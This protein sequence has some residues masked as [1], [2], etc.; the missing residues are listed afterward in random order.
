[1]DLLEKYII[2]VDE[3]KTLTERNVIP[4]RKN[5]LK[6]FS[7]QELVLKIVLLRK[8]MMEGEEIYIKNVLND[9]K[10]VC[11]KED[12]EDIHKL[13]TKINQLFN[14]E[15][16]YSLPNS[17]IQH[18]YHSVTDLLYGL[19]LHSD[20]EKIEN[21]ILSDKELKKHL[22]FRFIKEFDPIIYK[23]YDMIKKSIKLDFSEPIEQKS[24]ILHFI[25]KTKVNRKVKR[26]PYW[27][28]IDGYDAFP[29]DVKK[30]LSELS[31]K[32]KQVLNITQ[33]FISLLCEEKINTQKILKLL[34]FSSPISQHLDENSKQLKSFNNIVLSTKIRYSLDLKYAY[35]LLF[36]NGEY[37]F[38]VEK[39]Q[40]IPEAYCIRLKR[41]FFYNSYKIH[42]FV[43]ELP[44]H[45]M[46]TTKNLL[47]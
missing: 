23:L 16:S 30:S 44:K 20:T 42:S 39:P 38:I 37:P 25:E 40:L 32:D 36:K 9:F 18:L 14:L 29:T 45:Y 11:S 3:Y 35:V 8:F 5:D 34:S 33:N 41:H 31:V 10:N 47:K 12:S 19:Y 6:F 1:M 15:I 13:E 28:N 7:Y 17:K 4:S 22:L 2:L 26:S 43:K 24:P 46:I 27:S 21:S